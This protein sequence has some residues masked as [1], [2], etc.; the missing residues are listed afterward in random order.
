MAEAVHTPAP[1]PRAALL[2]LLTINLF[3]YVDRYVLAAVEPEIRR[4]F[5]QGGEAS[6]LSARDQKMAEMA[7]TG[8]LAT[9]FLVSYMVAAPVFGWLAGRMSRWVLVGIA[10]GVWS[11]ASGASGLAGTFAILP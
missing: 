4:H 7:K 3:N 9:A 6:G 8:S 1:G 11:L 2:L 5:F 10:V